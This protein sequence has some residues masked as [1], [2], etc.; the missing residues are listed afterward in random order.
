MIVQDLTSCFTEPVATNL[1]K[2]AKANLVVGNEESVYTTCV[3][4]P[5]NFY[6]Q[7]VRTS[8]QLDDLMNSMEEFYRP[9]AADE[10][11]FSNPRVGD[12]CCAKFTEDD[13]FYRAV[14]TKVSSNAIGVHY[15]DY[16]NFEEI[17]LSRIKTLNPTFTDLGAQ[18]FNAKLFPF[19]PETTGDFE[20]VVTDKELKAKIVKK[21]ENNVYLVQLSDSNGTKLFA[22]GATTQQQ[23]GM[24]EKRSSK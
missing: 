9:L 10:E 14:I 4:S 23:Q 17:P 18:S 1:P 21:A 8:T 24:I 11:S 20:A 6:C 19:N 15:I 5:D 16:G 13:G 3:D 22:T 2:V 7:L 12:V